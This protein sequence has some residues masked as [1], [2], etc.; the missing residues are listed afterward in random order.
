MIIMKNFKNILTIAALS[1]IAFPTVANAENIDL[2][3]VTQSA[4]AQTD[5]KETHP[6]IELSLEKSELLH[7]EEEI[8]S[9]VIGSP[10]HINVLADSAHTLVVVPRKP[11]ASHFTILDK[12]GKILMQR[13][14]IVA[15]PNEDY[16]RVKRTC[17]GDNCQETS[18][19]YCPE[20][21][22]HEIEENTEN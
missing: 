3:P 10:V 6:T 20:G 14:V 8:G 17:T 22:C 19:Y 11:G 9:I 7:I 13:H 4:D 18:I 15:A 2:P 5:I 21:M 16:I 1:A 12:S